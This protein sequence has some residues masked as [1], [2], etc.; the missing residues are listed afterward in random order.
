LDQGIWEHLLKP[1]ARSDNFTRHHEVDL[2]VHD[3]K[4]AR[5]AEDIVNE[6]LTKMFYF[7]SESS[8]SKKASILTFLCPVAAARCSLQSLSADRKM[9]APVNRSPSINFKSFII[10]FI[11]SD[12]FF[13][14]SLR[15]LC[16]RI[17]TRS[18]RMC[19]WSWKFSN[20]KESSPL[21]STKIHSSYI[22]LGLRANVI[23]SRSIREEKSLE[24][25]IY[26]ALV[27]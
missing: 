3:R 21:G 5:L 10:L 7:H 23:Q 12:I 15:A 25:C 26:Y 17:S 22:L 27:K 2:F 20:W 1:T 18:Y 6:S 9:A 19:S 14:D 24:N 13:L 4:I 11:G 8:H 16:F